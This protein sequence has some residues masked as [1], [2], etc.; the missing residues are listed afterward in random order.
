MKMGKHY[1]YPVDR[2]SNPYGQKKVCKESP[3]WNSI[4]RIILS[5]PNFRNLT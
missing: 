5:F 2:K 3:V 1:E 4:V